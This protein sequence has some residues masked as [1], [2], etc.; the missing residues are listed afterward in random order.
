MMLS[1]FFVYFIAKDN[2]ESCKNPRGIMINNI[3]LFKKSA[4]F[5]ALSSTIT[6]PNYVTAEESSLEGIE[7]IQVTASRRASTV[8][9]AP[10]N[11][12]ALDS[13][14]MKNQNIGKLT[15]IARWVPGLSIPDQG[16]RSENNIIVRGLSTNSTG[17]QSDGGTVATY[18]GEIPLDV[19][20][21]L[22]DVERVEVLI[23]P[24]GTLYGAGTLGGAIRYI[25]KKAELD[26]TSVEL[27]GDF[28]KGTESDS[29][30]HESSIIVNVPLIEDTLAVRASFNLYKIRALL[31]MLIQS[32]KG[33][34]LLLIQIGVIQQT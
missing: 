19:D 15:E 16:G 18:F 33:A 20:V 9:D 17:S 2:D 27:S 12:T 31:I 32:E 3:Q 14:V 6:I 23:G 11:I 24:Q 34:F 10:L 25:P 7:R 13:D 4:V 22:I 28:F 30:G 5:L 1:L 26:V 21:R 8:Q 29:L